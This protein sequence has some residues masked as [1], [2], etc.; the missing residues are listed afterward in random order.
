[1]T[2]KLRHRAKGQVC[3]LK[4]RQLPL[5]EAKVRNRVRWRSEICQRCGSGTADE[6]TGLPGSR[7]LDAQCGRTL[8]GLGRF[9]SGYGA[10]EA[11][12]WRL[13]A[14][15]EP[16]AGPS[17]AS[18]RNNGASSH[19][20]QALCRRSGV[21]G[22]LFTRLKSKKPGQGVASRAQLLQKT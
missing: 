7:V 9:A 2:G 14:R 10:V 21:S 13:R 15:L 20:R 1:M 19:I 22:R 16:R 11:D 5:Q 17:W 6:H 3:H 12:N 18:N 8:H 4:G